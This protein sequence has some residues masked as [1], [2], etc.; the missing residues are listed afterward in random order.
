MVAIFISVDVFF[1]KYKKK[2]Y[3]RK[4]L[5]WQ[6]TIRCIIGESR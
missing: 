6:S 2:T 3:A 5:V 4:Y 1:L